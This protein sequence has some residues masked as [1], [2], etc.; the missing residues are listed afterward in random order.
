MI[1]LAGGNETGFWREYRVGIVVTAVLA[2]LTIAVFFLGAGRGPFVPDT[3]PLHVNLDEAGGIRIGSM[4]HVA[5]VAAGEVTNIEIIPA[6]RAR[7]PGDGERGDESELRDIRLE[8]HIDETFRPYITPSSR[9]RLA[10]LGLGAERYLQI[11]AGD[12]RE[13]PI[14]P[15]GTVRTVASVDWD[16]VL[17]KLSRALN[18]TNEILYLTGEVRTKTFQT[19]AGTI[20]LAIQ[21][22]SPLYPRFQGLLEESAALLDLIENGEGVVGQFERDGR[23][24]DHLEG[25]NENLDALERMMEVEEGALGHWL[26]PTELRAAMGELGGEIDSLRARLESGRGSGGRFLHD[27][28]LFV[29]IRALRERIAQLMAAFR[30]DPLGFVDINLF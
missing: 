13:E 28:E 14:E 20:G 30:A 25:L 1:G 24:K 19:R 2:M 22:D 6:E 8:I 18:E 12:A 10:N 23:L 11:S 3:Y 29:Q 5:G 17:A 16:L 7:S 9:A 21:P 27:D 26:E 15:G 4:V